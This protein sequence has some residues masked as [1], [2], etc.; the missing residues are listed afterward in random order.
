MVTVLIGE[1]TECNKYRVDEI[2][3]N[4]HHALIINR[5]TSKGFKLWLK[6]IKRPIIGGR[7]LLTITDNSKITRKDFDAMKDILGNLVDHDYIDVLWMIPYP[8][9][10]FSDVIT[11][12]NLVNLRDFYRTDFERYVQTKFPGVDSKSIKYLLNRISYNWNT[13][14]LYQEE[15][16]ARGTFNKRD[17]EKLVTT[18]SLTPIMDVLYANLLRIRSGLKDYYSYCERYSQTWVKNFY[19]DSIKDIL[20]L[21]IMYYR[22]NTITIAQIRGSDK[23]RKYYR[24]V[25][26]VPITDVY[27]LLSLLRTENYPLETYY[28]NG[29]KDIIKEVLN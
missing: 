22:H 23:Y 14:I 9:G 15:L 28:K 3:K 13:Y 10:S 6:N 2:K 29:T 8:A 26:S 5:N 25:T 17:I 21:K 1:I 4:Y 20:K 16:I 11:E 7:I 24:I 12:L 18:K 27:L 19:I